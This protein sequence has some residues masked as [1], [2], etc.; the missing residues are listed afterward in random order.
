MIYLLYKEVHDVEHKILKELSKV[1]E[2]NIQYFEQLFQVNAYSLLDSCK[3]V[4]ISED[5][6]FV[7][8]HDK[9]D[10]I[11][12]LL[13][14]KVKALEEYSTGDVYVFQKFCAPEVFGEMEALSDIC[15]YRASLI[16]ASECTFINVPVTIYLKFLKSNSEY[17]YRRT[18]DTLKRVLD[19]E[20]EKRRYFKLNGID[21]INLYFI[22]HFKLNMIDEV[23]V[24]KST[25]QEIADEIGFSIKTVNRAI[26]KLKAKNY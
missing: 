14:G 2:I 9:I 25:R 10:T 18:Q 11:W 23:C 12:I 13:A 4:T 19:D 22:Q 15:N 21:R 24:I 7:S 3:V 17:L 6:K 5:T 8:S 26:K 16:T 20:R 1:P